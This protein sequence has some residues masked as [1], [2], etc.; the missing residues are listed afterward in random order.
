MNVDCITVTHDQ[1]RPIF[2]T[3]ESVQNQSHRTFRHIIVVDRNPRLFDRISRFCSSYETVFVFQ[4]ETRSHTADLDHVV[5]L[6]RMAL[7]RTS[8]QAVA[9]IDDDD[10]WENRHLECLLPSLKD[11]EIVL[12]GCKVVNPDGSLALLDG[13]CPWETGHHKA[14]EQFEKLEDIGVYSREKSIS[15]PVVRREEE[16]IHI[17]CHTSTSLFDGKVARRLLPSFSSQLEYRKGEIHDIIFRGLKLGLRVKC[18]PISTATYRLGG[19][20]NGAIEF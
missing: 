3:I 12:S 15:F 6:R 20:S 16:E 18:L 11:H 8:G 19:F 1:K 4:S 5:A 14:R 7:G 13:V 9:Y 2:E 10:I 17:Y